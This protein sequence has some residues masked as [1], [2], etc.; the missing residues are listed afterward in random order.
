MGCTLAPPGQYEWTVRVL[1]WCGLVSNYF[2]HLLQYPVRKVETKCWSQWR[3]REN[4]RTAITLPRKKR[5][6]MDPIIETKYRRLVVSRLLPGVV[7]CWPRPLIVW[8]T[9]VDDSGRPIGLYFVNVFFL[10]L[11]FYQSSLRRPTTYILV[12]LI[13]ESC[14]VWC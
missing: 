10:C 12:K 14:T 11:F 2:D 7:T 3:Q 1:R 13:N 5:R 8:L 9:M 6:Y 4:I